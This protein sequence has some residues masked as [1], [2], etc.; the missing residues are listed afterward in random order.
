MKAASPAPPADRLELFINEGHVAMVDGTLVYS[1]GYGS[2]PADDPQPNLRIEPVVFLRDRAG[3]VASRHYPLDAAIPEHGHPADAGRRD[4]VGIG[5]H[6]I[7]RN[8]WASFFPPRTIVAETGSEI[9]LR[10][11]NRLKDP[12]TFTIRGVVDTTVAPG[13]SVAVEFP[14]PRPGTYLY[15]DTENAPVNRVLGL[16]GT[17]VV[18][19]A[20]APWTLDG[21][22][23]AFERQWLW[24]F[25]NIDPQW[26]RL[27]RMGTR[28]D[29]V[30]TPAVPRYFTLNDRSGVG[31]IGHSLDEDENARAHEDAKPG[32]HARLVDVRDFE[33]PGAGTGQLIRIINAG[34]AYHQPH[35]HGNHVWTIAVDNVTLSRSTPALTADGHIRLQHWEDVVEID[36]LATK[37]VMLP[38]KTPPDAL[39]EVVAAQDRDWHYPMHCHAEMSQTAGGGLYPGGIL[40]DWIL[41]P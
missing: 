32:G 10:I 34:V 3:P 2:A 23:G 1:R 9:R 41:K 14:A 6:H 25:A 11:T 15:H 21:R 13:E 12:H 35:F 24:V 5:L 18:V 4:D 33:T 17:L 16:Y 31:A 27:T 8:H 36:P 39:D 7:H 19:P 26:A 28:V 22:E 30:K 20:D 40:S 38:I 37:A 29:P